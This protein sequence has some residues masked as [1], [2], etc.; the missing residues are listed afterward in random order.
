MYYSIQNRIIKRKND[1]IIA[2]RIENRRIL[3]AKCP[4]VFTYFEYEVNLYDS[5]EFCK[6]WIPHQ[7]WLMKNKV[8]LE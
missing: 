2:E 6:E 4:G 1:K 7:R 3:I 5:I 8:N